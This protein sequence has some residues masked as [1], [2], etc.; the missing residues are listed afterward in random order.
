MTIIY[1]MP[2]CGK[3]D[4]AKDKLS[5]FFNIDYEERSYKEHVTYHDGWRNDGSL[6]VLAAKCFYGDKAV[7]LMSHDGEMYDYPKLVKTLKN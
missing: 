5:R 1:S 7:P 4:A 6:D 2:N 3:C